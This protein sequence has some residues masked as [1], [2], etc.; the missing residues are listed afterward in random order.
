MATLEKAIQLAA[1]YHAGATD[2]AGQPYILH[3]LRVMSAL[4]LGA[5][6]T[7][8][9]IAV[10]HDLLEDTPVTEEM[11]KHEG[12]SPEVIN[13]VKLLT[14]TEDVVEDTYFLRIMDNPDARVVKLEDIKDNMDY[15]RFKNKR[16]M[17]PKD[18]ER[19]GKY[20]K[21]WLQLSGE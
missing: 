15:R 20:M 16:D 10:M 13:G 1:K 17:G 5:S 21:R 14:K 8:R 19:F 7:R 2:R 12:F 3:P 18:F 9:M 6:N 4:G 11:L